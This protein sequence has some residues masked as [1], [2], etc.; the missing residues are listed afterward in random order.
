MKRLIFA[1]AL[2]LA[3]PAFADAGFFKDFVI[4]NAGD[5][6]A[7]YDT[8]GVDETTDFQ[9]LDLGSYCAG[10]DTLILAGAE[11]NTFQNGNDFVDFAR[12]N[13]TVYPADSPPSSLE[14]TGDYLFFQAE[15][16]N[17]FGGVDKVWRSTDF[18][19]DLIAAAQS[20]GEDTTF[21]LQVYFDGQA[22]F[23]CG[24]FPFF[25]SNFGANYTATYTVLGDSDGDGTCDQADGCPDDPDKTEAGSCGCGNAET[26]SDEDGTP[27]CIDGCPGDG[28]K[29]ASGS[30]G[31]GNAETDSDEDGTP[32]CIDGCPFNG[33]KA[34]PG[35]C[36]CG[37][38]DDALTACLVEYCGAVDEDVFEV[39]AETF[40]AA[41]IAVCF[42]VDDADADGVADQADACPG[43]LEGATVDASGCSGSQAVA[44]AC[45]AAGSWK[46]HGAY[47]SCVSKA[48]EAQ[49]EQG[50][51]TDA[52]ADAL[53]S[54]AAKSKVGKPNKN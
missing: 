39:C 2:A 42:P 21:A 33:N 12:I 11:A 4:V 43:T 22:S 37:P 3:P 53:V 1:L 6:D 54:A 52:E 28:A 16:P 24:S 30:C 25:D 48:A 14:F 45:D 9:G 35:S 8:Y 49:V 29:I 38:E 40:C 15:F 41:E 27:D 17:P 34:A 7:Y 32:D 19:Y 18:G 46:N 23:C 26:D 20:P 31:C 10:T 5:G 50:L 51:L 44:A 13:Y 47:V 36:G